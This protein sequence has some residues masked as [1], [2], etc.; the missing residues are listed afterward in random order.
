SFLP[1]AIG[2]LTATGLLHAAGFAAATFARGTLRYAGAA[3]AMVGA[4]LLFA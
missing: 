3:I 2:F 4:I 1:Y